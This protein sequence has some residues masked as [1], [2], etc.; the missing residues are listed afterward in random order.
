MNIN[1]NFNDVTIFNSKKLLLIGP[2]TKDVNKL[3]L[4][5][6]DYIFLF[7]FYSKYLKYLE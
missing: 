3:N 4:E 6:Y 7:G 2:T 5:T 1:R